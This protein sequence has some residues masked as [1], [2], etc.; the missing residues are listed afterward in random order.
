MRKNYSDKKPVDNSSI[1]A[2][3]NPYG[4]RINI[5]NPKIKPLYEKYKR[6][7]KIMIPS[8]KERKRFEDM[9]FQLIERKKHD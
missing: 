9:I 1:Y 3:G 6:K 5:N 4:Y 8:D 7:Y 2:T